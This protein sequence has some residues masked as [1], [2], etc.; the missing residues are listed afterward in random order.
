LNTQSNEENAWVERI[1]FLA[2]NLSNIFNLEELSQ[3]NLRGERAKMNF[4]GC[5]FG[6]TPRE[7]HRCSSWEFKKF[8]HLCVFSIGREMW[9]WQP[10]GFW[11]YH[12]EE[13]TRVGMYE[14]RQPENESIKA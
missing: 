6:G 4:S 2:L 3:E 1:I 13:A 9:R 10:R 7:N 12:H 8:F 14:T 11:G 5:S